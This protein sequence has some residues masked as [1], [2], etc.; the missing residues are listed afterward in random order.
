MSKILAD[1][2]KKK[3]KIKILKINS[4]DLIHHPSG[5]SFAKGNNIIYTVIQYIINLTN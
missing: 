5:I 3:R 1:Y 4:L 2:T